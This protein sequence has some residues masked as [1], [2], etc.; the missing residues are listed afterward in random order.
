MSD[1]NPILKKLDLLYPR[2]GCALHF[3]GPFQL[4]V[5]TILSAQCTDKRVNIVTPV[6]F[7]KFGTVKK[8][9][10]ERMTE[11][12]K[13]IRSTGFY[14]NK[15][16]NILGASKMLVKKFHGNVPRTMKEI[17]E[18]PGVARKTAN[19]V[20]SVAYGI[21]EGIAVDTHVMR[22][23]GRLGLS[24]KKTPEKIEQDLLKIIP[25][26][27]WGRFSLQL[28]QHGRLV[29]MARSPLC[30][31]CTL[32]KICPSAFLYSKKVPQKRGARRGRDTLGVKL[33]TKKG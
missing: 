12:E 15:A 19:V 23:S 22:L 27:K 2:V 33:H 30:D 5:A 9:A 26:K 31:D 25:R 13:I 28:I 6:L 1:P 4:L 8:M 3:D 16:K 32:N 20:L 18:L 21:Q 10:S 11:I 17:L 7:A 24:D 14:H 29:C